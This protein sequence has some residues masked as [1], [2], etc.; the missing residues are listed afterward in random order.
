MTVTVREALFTEP[1]LRENYKRT[2]DGTAVFFVARAFF[3]SVGTTNLKKLNLK[4]GTLSIKS[5]V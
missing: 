3:Q 2:R 1:I 5:I 4:Y